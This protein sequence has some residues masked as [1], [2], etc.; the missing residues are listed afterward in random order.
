MQWSLGWL[1]MD[2]MPKCMVRITEF[3]CI[4]IVISSEFI[5]QRMQW[6]H[7]YLFKFGMVNHG[8]DAKVHG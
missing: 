7:S 2:M 5:V 3:G 1:I 6:G 8:Y 4:K